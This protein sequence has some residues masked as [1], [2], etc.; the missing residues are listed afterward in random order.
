[1]LGGPPNPPLHL[2]VTNVEPGILPESELACALILKSLLFQYRK[3]TTTQISQ[4]PQF[5]LESK[6][7][8]ETL[9]N[10]VQ[11]TKQILYLT[12]TGQSL[13]QVKLNL[14][15]PLLIVLGDDQGLSNRH[16]KTV[17]QYSVTEVSIGTRSLLGS[18]VLSLLLL[19]LARRIK[20]H[21]PK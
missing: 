14:N 8:S 20:H 21:Q 18:Q 19:E 15:Q 16:E 3:Q 6:S 12:E 2:C 11:A 13:A 5:T 1:M 10:K 17:H 7:F 4:W 9:Q